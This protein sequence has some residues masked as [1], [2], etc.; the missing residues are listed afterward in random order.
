MASV[1]LENTPLTT[2]RVLVIGLGTTGGR[3]VDT[4]IERIEDLHDGGLADVPWL[5]VLVLETENMTSNKPSCR[6]NNYHQ[7]KLT[8]SRISEAKTNPSLLEPAND[9]PKWTVDTIIQTWPDGPGAGNVR[10]IGRARLLHPDVLPHIM[11]QITQRI[12]TLK[13]Y[14]GTITD[15]SGRSRIFDGNERID[16]FLCGTLV[17]GTGSGSMIDLGYIL[18]RHAR[19]IDKVNLIGL[20]SVPG[21]SLQDNNLK[22]NAYQALTELAHFDVPGTRYWQRV[23]LPEAFPGG[24]FLECPEGTQPLDSV[25]LIQP[26]SKSIDNDLRLMISSSAELINSF[27]LSQ[28]S[29]DVR[30]KLIN[31]TTRYASVY[32]KSGLPQR[33]CSIGVSIIE[34]PVERIA[35]GCGARLASEALERWLRS[36]GF[37]SQMAMNWFANRLAL[38]SHSLVDKLTATSNEGTTFDQRVGSVIKDAS[39]RARSQGAPELS[40][41][42]QALEVGFEPAKSDLGVVKAG[43]FVRGIQ[44]REKVVTEQ[45]LDELRTLITE[46]ITDGTRG[47]EWVEQSIQIWRTRLRQEATQLDQLVD[48][49]ILNDYKDSMDDLRIR[50][51]QAQSSIL[52]LLLGWR[53]VAVDK[54][55]GEYEE[56]ALQYWQQR[57][58]QRAATVIKRIYDQVAALLDKVDLRLT[59]DNFGLKQWAATLQLELGRMYVE[60]RD[61]KVNIN[62]YCDFSPG[63]GQTLDQEYSKILN[64]L[65]QTDRPDLSK[66]SDIPTHH[67]LVLLRDWDVTLPGDVRVKFLENALLARD[68]SP[69][70][71]DTVGEGE[72]SRNPTSA[73][74]QDLLRRARKPF[75]DKLEQVNICERLVRMNKL[76]EVANAVGSAAPFIG[77]ND[78]NTLP[79]TPAGSDP[80]IPNFAFMRGFGQAEGTVFDQIKQAGSWDRPIESSTP[81]RITLIRA[82]ACFSGFAVAD[83]AAFRP[84]WQEQQGKFE[85]RTRKD[86]RWRALDGSEPIPQFTLR[87]SAVLMAIALDIVQYAGGF[88]VK[89]T[90][91][92]GRQ[93][94]YVLSES[95]DESAIRIDDEGYS[96]ELAEMIRDVVARDG[97]HATATRLANFAYELTHDGARATMTWHGARLQRES[98]QEK[99]AESEA[100]IIAHMRTFAET[101][102]EFWPELKIKLQKLNL[103]HFRK[104]P[105]GFVC[106]YCGFFLGDSGKHEE[107]AQ[108]KGCPHCP[109]KYD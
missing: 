100:K 26:K 42:E 39:E 94:T 85:S 20:I 59:D 49:Q 38:T 96:K 86:I 16:V 35:R 40:S 34:Y 93:R 44:D 70:D 12:E 28:S 62:G 54:I 30:A 41:I 37:E 47:A 109:Q 52:L 90:D 80:R 3:I 81:Y 71:R 87:K 66:T 58:Q 67:Q 75:R 25:F 101:I 27:V 84:F 13:S 72:Q 43:E 50:L 48:G 104:E 74:L 89:F 73:E 91:P 65:G 11:D 15:K 82:R 69:F 21:S 105:L 55:L 60:D 64:D 10:M 19:F 18:R 108:L 17:G 36:G 8:S 4:I 2:P 31:P 7:L 107:V 33:F 6:T 63:E 78:I 22:A 106:N 32:D 9:F 79:G 5:K 45:R 46:M 77:L 68:W 1:S 102:P 24:G 51:D 103:M 95:I 23:P 14:D 92:T 57:L 98:D 29:S 56:V 53:G 61:E 88:S 76:T 99:M 83:V 97:H